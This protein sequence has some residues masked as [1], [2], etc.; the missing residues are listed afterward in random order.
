MNIK[1]IAKL[2]RKMNKA[3]NKAVNE[4]IDQ[5]IIHE[6]IYKV[7]LNDPDVGLRFTDCDIKFE[8][9]FEDK[10][11]VTKPNKMFCNPKLDLR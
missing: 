1:E 5:L 2:K 10:N 7:N 9:N 4:I 6:D 3:C 11:G 8:L